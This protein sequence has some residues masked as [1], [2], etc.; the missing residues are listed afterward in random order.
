MH[1][2]TDSDRGVQML[3]ASLHKVTREVLRNLKRNAYEKNLLA[4]SVKKIMLMYKGG[5]LNA[6]LIWAK[7]AG[8][9]AQK[10]EIF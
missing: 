8:L 9:S 2:R 5:L 4:K 10:D 7:Q 1:R 3:Q 6:F